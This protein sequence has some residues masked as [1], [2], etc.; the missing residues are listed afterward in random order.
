MDIYKKYGNPDE[1]IIFGGW[2]IVLAIG[3]G[4]IGI[5]GGFYSMFVIKDIFAAHGIKPEEIPAAHIATTVVIS[6][7]AFAM[8]MLNLIAYAR[9]FNTPKLPKRKY[10]F[11]DL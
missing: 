6:A 3:A 5:V 10:N 4:A 11:K 2:A 1:D 9:R 7:F 8:G